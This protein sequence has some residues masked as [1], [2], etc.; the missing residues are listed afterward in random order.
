MKLP[1]LTD[2]VSGG[3]RFERQGRAE[4]G[5]AGSASGAAAGAEEGQVR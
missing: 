2:G 3:S 4:S 1:S 5:F